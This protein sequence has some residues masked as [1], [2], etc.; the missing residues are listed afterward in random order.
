[1]V[2]HLFLLHSRLFPYP[3]SSKVKCYFLSASL[4]LLPAYYLRE[5]AL[6]IGLVALHIAC[7]MV[8]GASWTRGYADVYVQ[9][10]VNVQVRYEYVVN[11]LPGR[12]LLICYYGFIRNKHFVWMHSTHLL[13]VY[14]VGVDYFVGMLV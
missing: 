13:E 5:F 6:I 8:P 1:M 11:Y 14:L 10:Q 2:P 3:H 7:V 9:V 12:W 4:T